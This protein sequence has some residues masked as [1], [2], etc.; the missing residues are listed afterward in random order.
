[1]KRH[2]FTSYPLFALI[3]LILSPLAVVHASPSPAD[4]VHFCAPFDY[5]QWRSE[6]LRPA[7]KRLAAFYAVRS[8]HGSDDL[9]IA[10]LKGRIVPIRSDSIKTVML[11]VQTYYA[12]QMQAQ[13]Y[14][15]L[16]LPY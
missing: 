2:C 14:V 15:Q 12:D 16:N 6:H 5:E 10:Q 1:M 8:A 13:G 11:R 7:G 9:P 3:G 4:S